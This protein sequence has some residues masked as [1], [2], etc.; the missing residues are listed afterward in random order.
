MRSTQPN[1]ERPRHFLPSGTSSDLFV[2]QESSVVC[3]SNC[4][5][6]EIVKF[7]ESF[8]FRK[9]CESNRTSGEPVI[10]VLPPNVSR[11]TENA[12][13]RKNPSAI[14]CREGDRWQKVAMERLRGDI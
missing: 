13:G 14:F 12:L 9:F 11:E 7:C 8:D 1:V 2:D 10:V 5:A 6:G 3:G 4:R